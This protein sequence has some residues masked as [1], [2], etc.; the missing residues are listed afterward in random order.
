METIIDLL[1]QLPKYEVQIEAWQLKNIQI[2]DHRVFAGNN[3]VTPVIDFY[4]Q[5]RGMTRLYHRIGAVDISTQ[6]LEEQIYPFLNDICDAYPAARSKLRA[7]VRQAFAMHEYI[8]LM[9]GG[10]VSFASGQIYAERDPIWLQRGL[11]GLAIMDSVQAGTH[12]WLGGLYLAAYHMRIDVD[13]S[14]E[15]AVKGC[16][17]EPSKDSVDNVSMRD[18]VSGFKDSDFF[19]HEIAPKL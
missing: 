11:A 7:G 9:F 17:A 3:P 13:A 19:R 16:S 5:R 4:F 10:Y 2:A 12:H 15:S 18:F 14:F 8:R 1:R 6:W